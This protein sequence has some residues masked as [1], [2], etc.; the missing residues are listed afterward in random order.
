MS[1]PIL[2]PV[3]AW[4]QP[5]DHQ[6]F[7]LRAAAL[8]HNKLGSIGLLSEAIGLSNAAL[9]MALNYKG[10]TPKHAIAIEKLLGREH[11]PRELFRPDI[12]LTA[13]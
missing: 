9:H 8:Y 7:A 3:P 2:L 4:A 11:F 13:E 5:D 6:E 10:I 12:F 1:K